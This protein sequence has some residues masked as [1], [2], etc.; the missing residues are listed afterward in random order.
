[1]RADRPLMPSD[2]RRISAPR[3]G[4]HR[5]EAAAYVGISS[6][7][8]DEMVNDGRMPKAK[9]IDCRKVWDIRA[10]D[11]AFDDLPSEG[12]ANPWDRPGAS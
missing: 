10:L 8:F 2:L 7:K 1:M 11:L 9:K 6:S 3:R 5:E 4:L 12:D